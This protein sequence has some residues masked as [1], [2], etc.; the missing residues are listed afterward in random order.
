MSSGTTRR[1][2]E[3]F[4]KGELRLAELPP[5]AEM[6]KTPGWDSLKQVELVLE[7]GS[8]FACSIPPDMIGDLISL[9]SIVAYLTKEGVLQDRKAA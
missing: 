1:E 6:G 7:M 4:I 3:E 8:R 5:D 2:L 9:E